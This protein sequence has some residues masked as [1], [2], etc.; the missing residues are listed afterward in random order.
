MTKIVA[1]FLPGQWR[2]D[3]N[4]QRHNFFLRFEGQKLAFEIY[5]WFQVNATGYHAVEPVLTS[6]I[7]EEYDFFNRGKMYHHVVLS[8]DRD[9]LLF[10]LT[11]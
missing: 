4:E 8:K 1:H 2:Y 3:G 9:A 6:N 10:K 7:E 11:W 5:D